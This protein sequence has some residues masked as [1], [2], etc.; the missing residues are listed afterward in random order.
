MKNFLM[1]H[2]VVVTVILVMAGII[3]W[4]MYKYGQCRKVGFSVAYCLFSKN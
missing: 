2:A 4:E 1:W 3:Y